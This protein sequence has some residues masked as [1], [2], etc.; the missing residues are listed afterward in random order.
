MVPMQLGSV[1]KRNFVVV[2]LG[3]ERKKIVSVNAAHAR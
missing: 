3:L 2:Q 1:V